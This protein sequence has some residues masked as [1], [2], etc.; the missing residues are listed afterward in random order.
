MSGWF[1]IAPAH[2]PNKFDEYGRVTNADELA[3]QAAIEAAKRMAKDMNMLDTSP[4]SGRNMLD[5]LKNPMRAMDG[6][7]NWIWQPESLPPVAVAN[8]SCV[9]MSSILQTVVPSAHLS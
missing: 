9:A 2:A 8:G 5:L 3:K 7:Q 4:F 1:P 6:C